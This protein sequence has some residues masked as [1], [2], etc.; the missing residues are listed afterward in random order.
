MEHPIRPFFFKGIR[1]FY[2]RFNQIY[3]FLMIIQ[4][5]IAFVV[6]HSNKTWLSW[7]RLFCANAHYEASLLN[8]KHLFRFCKRQSNPSFITRVIFDCLYFVQL[9]QLR[10]HSSTISVLFLCQIKVIF[11]VF[12]KKYFLGVY[13]FSQVE[14][15]SAKWAWPKK[16][17]SFI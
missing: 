5:Y 12:L 9:L 10:S 3:V 6:L 4:I 8:L 15:M 14:D 11:V 13:F 7:V 17:M 16:R 1:R 2:P